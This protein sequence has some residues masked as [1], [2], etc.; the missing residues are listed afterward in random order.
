MCVGSSSERGT[1]STKSSGRP[2]QA[3]AEIEGIHPKRT[4]VRR[5]ERLVSPP[6]PPVGRLVA[7]GFL[8]EWPDAGA[9][10]KFG[11]HRVPGG[12]PWWKKARRIAVSIA[13]NNRSSSL[14][15]SRRC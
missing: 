12:Q 14:G 15:I 8:L 2:T 6:P 7:K 4:K 10:G 1:V 11:R 13:I 9:G 3:E 5:K